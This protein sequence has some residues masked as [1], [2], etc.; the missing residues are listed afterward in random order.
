MKRPTPATVISIV[1]LFVSL[2]GTSLA[3]S[4]YLLTSVSKQASPQAR[5]EI[6]AL[7]KRGTANPTATAPGA[8]GSVGAAGP[9]GVAGL[10]VVGQEGKAGQTGA[11]GQN[12]E[13]GGRGPTGP[14]GPANLPTEAGEAFGGAEPIAAGAVLTI[15]ATCIPGQHAV[16]GGWKVSG[17][18]VAIEAALLTGDG[19]GYAV[20]FANGSGS[21]VTAAPIVWCVKP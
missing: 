9:A 10:S 8:A 16:A 4:H 6:A 7:V 5:R 1:A 18:G 3:A 15:T 17:T 21:T 2:G 14:A 11:P 13:P 19:E 20:T 12:G